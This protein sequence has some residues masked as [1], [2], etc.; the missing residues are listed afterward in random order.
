MYYDPECQRPVYPAS[1]APARRAP[2]ALAHLAGCL[3]LSPMGSVAP[4]L[5]P[6]S[7]P[8]SSPGVLVP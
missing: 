5:A 6:V 4:H 3:C 7:L 2:L 8:Y 1:P